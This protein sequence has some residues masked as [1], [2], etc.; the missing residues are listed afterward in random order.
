MKN[1]FL[2]VILVF[3]QSCIPLRIAPNI[4]DY[5]ITK[6]KTFKRGLTKHHVFIFEDPKDESEFYNYVDVKYQLYN[7]DVF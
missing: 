1:V 7:I 6:G 2:V 4:Q 3:V 5:K